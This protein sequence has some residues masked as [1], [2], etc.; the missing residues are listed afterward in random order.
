[1]ADDGAVRLSTL[2]RQIQAMQNELRRLKHDMQVHDQEVR[3]VA[4]QAAHAQATADQRALAL[5]PQVPAGF[6]LVP[7]ATPGSYAMAPI[8]PALPQLKQGTFQVGGVR[9]TLGGFIEA[10]SIFRSRNEVADLAS[11]FSTGIPLPNSPLY[12]ENEERF[13][14]RQ[15]RFSVMAQ[16]NPD[17]VTTLTAYFEGDLLGA[18]PTAN[19]NESDSYTPRLRHAF[20]VYD[21]SDLGLYFLGGQT[22]SL[23]TQDKK[24]ISYMLSGVN[25][26]VGI[27]AQN[28]VGFVWTRQPQFR[29]VKTFA[30]GMFS[31]G[32]SVENPQTVYYAGPNGE[33]SNLGTVNVSNTGGSGLNSPSTSNS[34]GVGSNV[35]YST[36]VAPDVVGKVA[37]DPSWG[38]IEA[39]GIARFPHDHIANATTGISL[40]NTTVAGGGGAALFVPI[41]PHMLDFQAS[42][43]AGRGIGRY[44]SAQLPDAIV[45]ADGKPD[46]LPE[47]EALVGL[48]GHPTPM[49]D[50]YGYFGSE[51]ESRRYYALDVKGKTEQFG[52]GDPLYPNT[53][54]DVELGSGSGCVGNTSGVIQ[55]AIGAWWKFEKGPF[56]TMQVGPEYTYTRRTIFQ[57]VGPTPKTDENTIF[58][59]FRYYPFS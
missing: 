24:G 52:Y 21:R 46:P 57:G 19:S 20:A 40:S 13:S 1:M 34:E 15:S 5:A 27:D 41:V 49:L 32:A 31:V 14:A 58:L 4:A 8:E 28:F 44:G 30:D 37:F 47:T 26:P 10:A 12:H 11:S 56:G 36:E 59:S 22:W 39:Y 29:V 9:V 43:L 16:G 17:P 3:A 38:H 55:A 7:G 54:C 42:V 35:Q 51:Q 23:L 25:P 6:A 18:A 48:I 2:E 50:I 53:S 45:G 33:P